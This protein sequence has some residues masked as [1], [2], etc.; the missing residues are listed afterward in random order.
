MLD[1]EE[2]RQAVL[3]AELGHLW[4]D[5]ERIIRPAIYLDSQRTSDNRCAI[6]ISK[7]GG[8]PD[9][10]SEFIWP[11]D[12]YGPCIFLMQI[13]LEQLAA[14]DVE[15]LLPRSGLLSFFYSADG[16]R[17]GIGTLAGDPVYYF[18]ADTELLRAT[19]A[20]D[21]EFRDAAYYEDSSI[22][23]FYTGWSFPAFDEFKLNFATAP[24]M[25]R[26]CVCMSSWKSQTRIPRI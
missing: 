13:S 11:E 14:C 2:L 8:V 15:G 3:E 6:G 22:L 18:P 9:F 23:S 12:E 25:R 26:I 19:P 10:P 1:K 4:D 24:T 21:S 16:M 5:I 20:Y 7:S 17:G